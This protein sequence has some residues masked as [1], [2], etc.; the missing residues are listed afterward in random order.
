MNGPG[1]FT[2]IGCKTIAILLIVLAL[3]FLAKNNLNYT[4]IYYDEL[5]SFWISQGLHNYSGVNEPAKGFHEMIRQNR[6]SN[7]DPGGQVV[8]LRFWTILGKDL[9]WLRSLSFLFFL[10]SIVGLG[11]LAREWTGYSL[12]AFFAIAI[13]FAYD[14]ILYYAFEIRAYSMEVAGIIWGVLALSRVFKR[15]EIN[16]FFVLGLVCALFMWSRYTYTI[17]VASACF[18]GLVFILK[19]PERSRNKIIYRSFAFLVPVAVSLLLIYRFSLRAQLAR[20]MGRGYMEQWMLHGKSLAESL[21]FFQINFLSNLALPITIA[22][23]AFFVIRPL[24]RY[25]FFASDAKTDKRPDFI[26]FYWLILACQIF[27]LT[28][29]AAGFTPWYI[30]KKWSLY[31][32][33]LS[34]IALLLLFAELLWFLRAH[35]EGSKIRAMRYF[36]PATLIALLVMTL[37]L[38]GHAASYRHIYRVDLAPAIEYLETLKLPDKS[39]FVTGYEIPT[40]RYLYEY[41]PYRGSDKYPRV[42]RFQ[43]RPEWDKSV[44]IDAAGEGL[45]YFLTAQNDDDISK[46]LPS[47]KAQRIEG[48]S[49]HLLKVIPRD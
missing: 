4:G 32:V 29:S 17:F 48:V 22:L 37:V 34:M 44:P 41:G 14:P 36:R 42:F 47:N 38:S 15:P 18:A 43:T 5:A 9:T 31:L 25:Q 13:P 39:V 23:L 11:L 27:S 2:D 35:K 33:A 7:L 10:L 28:F 46:R 49:Q 24:L 6:R 3:F 26:P 1:K 45:L 21:K 30:D 40:V 8:L 12:F 20:G 19:I 16:N